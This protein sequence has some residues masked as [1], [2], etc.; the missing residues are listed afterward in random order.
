MGLELAWRLRMQRHPHF[1]MDD[2]GRVRLE[3]RLD[4]RPNEAVHVLPIAAVREVSA[5]KGVHRLGQ[6]RA[7]GVDESAAQLQIVRLLP[8]LRELFKDDVCVSG[9]KRA[10][11]TQRD[12]PVSAGC[13]HEAQE[14]RRGLELHRHRCIV[15]VCRLTRQEHESSARRCQRERRPEAPRQEKRLG[16]GN[17]RSEGAKAKQRLRAS[18][19]HHAT[20]ISSPLGARCKRCGM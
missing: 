3:L 14:L 7:R 20:A 5:P 2:R 11:G 13:G 15:R 16:F 6:S 12:V 18:D 17:K 10:L 8:T 4:L 9:Q 1:M 19:T